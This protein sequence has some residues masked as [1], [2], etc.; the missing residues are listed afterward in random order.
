M[1]IGQKVLVKSIG[2]QARYGTSIVKDKIK[3]IGRKYFKLEDN[4]CR[5]IIETL[6]ADPGQYISNYQVYFSMKEIEDE[7]RVSELNRKIS[8]L[9]TYSNSNLPLEKLEKI[10]RIVE[11]GK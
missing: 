8:N 4:N 9:F 11:G 7:K 10:N 1:K 2:N 5:F 6:Y 3:S